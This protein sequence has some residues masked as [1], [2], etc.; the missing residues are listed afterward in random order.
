MFTKYNNYHD[1]LTFMPFH[2]YIITSFLQKQL[3]FLLITFMLSYMGANMA[4]LHKAQTSNVLKNVLTHIMTKHAH[5]F[6]KTQ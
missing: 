3:I 6:F 5:V 2:I 4:K 1:L